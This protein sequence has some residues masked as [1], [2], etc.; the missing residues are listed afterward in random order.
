MIEGAEANCTPG[1]H[2]QY[3]R[4]RAKHALLLFYFDSWNTTVFYIII[5]IMTDLF[6]NVILVYCCEIAVHG[7]I[8]VI[9]IH[10][11]AYKVIQ[12]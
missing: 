1:H 3:C 11:W 4:E 7:S 2:A 9:L 6:V 10:M 5:I 12:M 8:L